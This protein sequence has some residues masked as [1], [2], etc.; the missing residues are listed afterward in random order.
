[1]QDSP[2]L[3]ELH[4]CGPVNRDAGEGLRSEGEP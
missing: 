1:M 3:G 4:L 2:S